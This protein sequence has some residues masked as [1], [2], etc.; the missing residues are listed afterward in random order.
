MLPS[1]S[2]MLKQLPKLP[3]TIK[4]LFQSL[5]RRPTTIVAMVREQLHYSIITCSSTDEHR[6]DLI[7]E[8]KIW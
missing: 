1:R 8:R 5:R 7:F 3:V 6:D 4:C 2:G